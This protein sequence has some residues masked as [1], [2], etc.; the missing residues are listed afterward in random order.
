M[1]NNIL[2]IADQD[3]DRHAA[4]QKARD[5]A[6]T[7]DIK[8]T[9]L[10]FVPPGAGDTEGAVAAKDAALQAAIDEVFSESKDVSYQVVVASDIAAYCKA[11]TTEHGI[12]LVI[13][14]GHRSES[15]FYTP[16]DWQLIR[17]LK[18]P[19]LITTVQK[20]RAKR[21]VMVTIDIGSD[22][23]AQIALNEKVAKWAASWADCQHS[24]LHIAYCVVVNEALT[25]LDIVS[26]DEALVKHEASARAKLQD[27]LDAQG[28]K[29]A[30][31]EIAAGSPDRILPKLANKLKA[32]LV[33][34]GS[35]GRTGVKGVLL[36]NTAE[37]TMHNLRT[38]L[39]VIHP[40]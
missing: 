26:K 2:V 17:Q 5:I 35:V 8:I 27:F 32:D 13:K 20:W 1:Y 24:E 6:F 12:D 39:A 7:N 23:P 21:K 31:I 36:G 22:N 15:L 11:Y 3:T 30:S 37:K 9:V 14:T 40:D 33:V 18:C 19:V 10:G 25:E 4:M 38:D 29:C 28:V 16:T 34:L